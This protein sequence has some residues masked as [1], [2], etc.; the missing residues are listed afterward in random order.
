MVPVSRHDLD[1]AHDAMHRAHRYLSR[2]DPASSGHESLTERLKEVGAVAAGAA[3][4]GVLTGRLASSNIGATSIPWGLA[5]GVG[6]QAADAMGWAG[7]YGRVAGNLGTGAIAAWA[8]NWGIGVGANMLS[9]ANAQANPPAQAGV[10][11]IGACTG[12][13][14]YG[15]AGA[16]PMMLPMVRP[17]TEAELAARAYSRAA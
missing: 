9:K 6:L 16:S 2:R 3:G 14:T 7:K 15:G 10:A 11:G 13:A 17:I 4:I 5:I 1:E 12:C 8:N